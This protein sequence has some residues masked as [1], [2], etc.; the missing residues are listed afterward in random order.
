[1]SLINLPLEACTGSARAATWLL[2]ELVVQNQDFDKEGDSMRGVV[3]LLFLA[4]LHSSTRNNNSIV[5][6]R[7]AAPFHTTTQPH[8]E[9]S[10]TL[11][12]GKRHGL[13]DDNVNLLTH[14]LC[15][16]KPL[17][18]SKPIFP[19]FRLHTLPPNRKNE[20]VRQLRQ[21]MAKSAPLP[22]ASTEAPHTN[23]TSDF[24]VSTVEFFLLI[25][26]SP[27]RSC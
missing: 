11:D 18:H 6:D 4:R 16:A 19:A 12:L 17:A 22:S 26:C 21:L 13:V 7:Q 23:K 15:C 25:C 9:N 24:Y 2:Y 14:M 5:A 10:P 8:F 1:M 3:T 20:S 27:L